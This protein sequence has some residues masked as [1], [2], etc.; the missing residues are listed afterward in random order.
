[1]SKPLNKLKLVIDCLCKTRRKKIA[2]DFVV[3]ETGLEHKAVL[4]VMRRLTK[5]GHLELI[6]KGKISNSNTGRAYSKNPTWKIVNR[7]SLPNRLKRKK[8]SGNIRDRIWK[9]MRIKRIFLL[10]DIMKLAEVKEATAMNYIHI[11]ERNKYARKVGLRAPREGCHW[12][13]IRDDGPDRP[14]LKEYPEHDVTLSLS[15]GVS[16]EGA[17]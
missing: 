7:K 6:D 8:K 9:A 14:A 2:S 4:R 1:M 13:L 17:A 12:Q 16:K 3:A 15:K 11:L 5:Q 10:K